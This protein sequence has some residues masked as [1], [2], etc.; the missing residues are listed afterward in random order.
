MKNPFVASLLC[1]LACASIA[2]LGG[3]VTHSFPKDSILIDGES[4]IQTP[5]GSGKVSAKEIRTGKAALPVK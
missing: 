4:T 2:L 1:A 3:C 5:W